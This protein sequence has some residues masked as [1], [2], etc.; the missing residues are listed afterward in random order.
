MRLR[1]VEQALNLNFEQ[2]GVVEACI[3]SYSHDMT[4]TTLL[5]RVWNAIL[6]IFGESAWQV[7]QRTLEGRV[8]TVIHTCVFDRREDLNRGEVISAV[9][10]FVLRYLVTIATVEQ[11]ETQYLI[12]QADWERNRFSDLHLE[13]VFARAMLGNGSNLPALNRNDVV[14]ILRDE[15]RAFSER[16]VEF[17]RN[18]DANP[19]MQ[20]LESLN[21]QFQQFSKSG[22]RLVGRPKEKMQD[23]SRMPTNAAEAAESMIVQSK[24]ILQQTAGLDD[25]NSLREISTADLLGEGI[26]LRKIYAAFNSQMNALRNPLLGGMFG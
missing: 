18:L 9:S 6:H 11:Q 17:E 19:M 25:A 12:P 15:R 26:K 13:E 2:I 5:S 24:N 22:R 8:D 14:A 3:D 1:D 23:P 21:N 16:M 4:I 10:E 20:M 7:A